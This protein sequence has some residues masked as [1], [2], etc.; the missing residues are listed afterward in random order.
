M[1][2]EGIKKD[3]KSE[4]DLIGLSSGYKKWSTLQRGFSGFGSTDNEIQELKWESPLDSRY[5]SERQERNE[6]I[7]HAMD[8]CA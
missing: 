7:R 3:G 4:K 6:D 5:Y 2:N 1:E 8:L